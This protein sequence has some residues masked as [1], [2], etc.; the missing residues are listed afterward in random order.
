MSAG[1]VIIY[2]PEE[3]FRQK[4]IA[5]TGVSQN[6]INA[7]TSEDEQFLRYKVNGSVKYG[8]AGKVENTGYTVISN[9]PFMEYYC[10]P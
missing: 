3:S 8:V 6:I 7:V 2:H 10:T 5:E 4:N 9:M 1:G